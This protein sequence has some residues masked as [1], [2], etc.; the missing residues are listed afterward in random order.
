MSR[1]AKKN[2]GLKCTRCGCADFRT[3]DGRPF[4]TVTTILIP[5]AIRRYKI[6]RHCGKRIRTRET[7]EKD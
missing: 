7:I 2:K 1:D 4:D 5:G 6:C 3:E